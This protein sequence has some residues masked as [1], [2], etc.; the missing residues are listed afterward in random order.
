[1]LDDLL[2]PYKI[3]SSNYRK[4]ENEDLKDHINRIGIT[5]YTRNLSEKEEAREGRM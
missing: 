2:L 3:D 5:F 1:M 4:I